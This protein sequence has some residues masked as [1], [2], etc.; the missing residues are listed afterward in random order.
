MRAKDEYRDRDEDEVTVL[1][2]LAGR[3]T[4]G[5]TVFEVRTHTDLDIDSI[6]SALSGL[7]DDGLIEVTTED[8]RTVLVPEE[9]VITAEQPEEDD[10]LFDSLKRQFPF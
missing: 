3:G 4:E 2:A 5:M 6:E 7:K 8:G 10:S 1:D 9:S